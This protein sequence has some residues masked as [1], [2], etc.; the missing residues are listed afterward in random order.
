MTLSHAEQRKIFCECGHSQLD[1]FAYGSW[2][3]WGCAYTY[4]RFAKNNNCSCKKWKK[5]RKKNKEM[6]PTP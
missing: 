3:G 4:G 6:K 2:Q 5:P 1:H